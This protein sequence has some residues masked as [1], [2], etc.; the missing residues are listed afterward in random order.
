MTKDELL[1]M[2]R[3][4]ISSL[5]FETLRNNAEKK[6]DARSRTFKPKG[7]SEEEIEHMLFYGGNKPEEDDASKIISTT[8]RESYDSGIPSITTSEIQE[9]ENSFEDMLKEVDGGS[10]VFDKQSNGYSM[11]MSIGKDGIEA[12]ASGSIQM[13]RNGELRWAYSLKNGLTVSTEDMLVDSG[14]KR[15]VEKLYNHYDAW[16]KDWR[17]KLTIV[18]GE[19]GGQEPEEAEAEMPEAGTNT[20]EA[21]E[22]EV[23]AP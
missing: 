21:P 12:G 10:V 7:L 3:E 9:F 11:K 22:G 15:L 18:P 16:Q 6:K 19:S 2:I 5:A 23:P 4:E 20:P 8:I 14:N 1:E 17:E 13:G